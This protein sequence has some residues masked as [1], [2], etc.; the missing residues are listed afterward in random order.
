V[1]DE[2][3]AQALQELRPART[4]TPL[5]SS[6]TSPS[7]IVV[8]TERG[9][10]AWRG[11]KSA[12]IGAAVLGLAAFVLSLVFAFS[13]RREEPKAA[14]SSAGQQTDS[15]A[16]LRAPVATTAPTDARP[17]IPPPPPPST[18]ATATDTPAP[19]TNEK[20]VRAT[21]KRTSGEKRVKP[22]GSSAGGVA[23][24]PGF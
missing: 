6:S 20:P 8:S 10:T 11:R 9:R 13:G 17:A 24:T 15:S 14:A 4:A 21:T 19:V 1:S 7:S 18:V 2:E 23:T 5:S 16:G 22:R 12:V 3:L